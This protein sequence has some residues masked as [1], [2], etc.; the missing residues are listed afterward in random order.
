M[1]NMNNFVAEISNLMWTDMVN[2]DDRNVANNTFNVLITA[3][4]NWQEVEHCAVDY[5]FSLN[6]ADDLI[7]CIQGGLTAIEITQMCNKASSDI[8]A[9]DY[10]LFGENYSMPKLLTNEQ[11]ASIINANL[12]KVITFV[13]HYGCESNTE[14]FRFIYNNYIAHR[15]DL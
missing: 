15:F 8:N 9:S 10:F 2:T 13:L 14:E 1:K 3:Y 6:K 5:L 7:C 11:L 4:N 12:T